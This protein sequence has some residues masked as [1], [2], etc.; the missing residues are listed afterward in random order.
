MSQDI[1]FCHV[2]VQTILTSRYINMSKNSFD[3][4]LYY[5]V[6]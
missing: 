3:Y 2:H 5:C 1:K 4:P 6:I